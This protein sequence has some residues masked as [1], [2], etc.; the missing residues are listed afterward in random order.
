MGPGSR[1]AYIPG[2]M[3]AIIVWFDSS[4]LNMHHLAT[5]IGFLHINF[6]RNQ[7]LR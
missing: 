3:Q 1:P 6:R 5:A 4:M 2:R 7:V